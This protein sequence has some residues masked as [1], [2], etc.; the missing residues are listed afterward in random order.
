MSDDVQVVVVDEVVEVTPVYLPGSGGNADLG[1]LTA[2]VDAAETELGAHDIRLDTLEQS[3]QEQNDRILA[4]EA[5]S[6]DPDAVGN[7]VNAALSVHV[8][9]AEPHPAYDDMPDLALIFESGLV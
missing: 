1:P 4:I 3:D 8:Q 6:G 7:I 2:R 9:A 5:T